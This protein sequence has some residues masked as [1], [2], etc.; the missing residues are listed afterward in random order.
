MQAILPPAGK[1]TSF[2]ATRSRSVSAGAVVVRSSTKFAATAAFVQLAAATA[3]MEHG[4]ARKKARLRCESAKTASKAGKAK[5]KPKQ[6]A[7]KPAQ[8]SIK[9][10]PGIS[11]ARKS[12]DS[13]SASSTQ[14]S[15]GSAAVNDGRSPWD[16]S[17][18]KS[19]FGYYQAHHSKLPNDGIASSEYVMNGP[20]PLGTKVVTQRM[21]TKITKY[22][23]EDATSEVRLDFRQEG[24]DWS[25]VKEN[26]IAAEYA[27]SSARLTI[28]SA[29]YGL[30]VASF[31]C[32]NKEITGVAVRKMKRSLR[33]VLVKKVHKPWSELQGGIDLSRKQYT[34]IE[35]PDYTQCIYSSPN[36]HAKTEVCLFVL[37]SSAREVAASVINPYTAS[38]HKQQLRKSTQAQAEEIKPSFLEH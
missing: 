37:P 20:K 13:S 14:G 27:P 2:L 38:I 7:I 15:S 35:A 33:L 36:Q 1:S 19:E 34:P 22:S 11:V 18:A 5:P 24:W 29:K 23:W 16:R 21:P 10:S 6:T 12:T 25:E 31:T 3:A 8:P 17:K 28:D 30:H 9:S 4:T 32:L 26:E